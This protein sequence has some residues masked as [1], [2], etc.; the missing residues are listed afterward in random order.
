MEKNF[1]INGMIFK[2]QSCIGDSNC[3]RLKYEDIYIIDNTACEDFYGDIDSVAEYMKYYI[4]DDAMKDYPWW[5]LIG[6]RFSYQEKII[7][8][9]IE[10]EAREI[11]EILSD[12]ENVR[13]VTAQSG[14]EFEEVKSNLNYDSYEGNVIRVFKNEGIWCFCLKEDY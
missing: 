4:I 6:A 1:E 10:T 9:E 14:A 12:C 2:V 3:Y 13:L 11:S 5:R 8:I 7:D